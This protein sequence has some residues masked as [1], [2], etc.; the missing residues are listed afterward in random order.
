MGR[1]RCGG[2][3]DGGGRAGAGIELHGGRAKARWRVRR[4]RLQGRLGSV[5]VEEAGGDDEV[6]G[7]EQ[8]ALEPC[9]LPVLDHCVDDDHGPAA[10]IYI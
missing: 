9:G 4:E 3:A 8:D 7:E 1:R 10:I 2:T 6:G 5:G